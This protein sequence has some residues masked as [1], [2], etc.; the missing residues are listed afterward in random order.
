MVPNYITIVL[1]DFLGYEED[2]NRT[3]DLN[4]YPQ[5]WYHRGNKLTFKYEWLCHADLQ[6]IKDFYK[7]VH[8]N[9]EDRGIFTIPTVVTKNFNGNLLQKSLVQNQYW[10]FTESQLNITPKIINNDYSSFDL[11]FQ[12]TSHIA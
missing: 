11:N 12:I 9:P 7:E 6:I 5:Q 8:L 1:S 3:Q 10:A 4:R 2:L